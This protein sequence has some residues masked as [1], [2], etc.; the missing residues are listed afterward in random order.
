MLTFCLLS[1]VLI[2]VFS[3]TSVYSTKDNFLIKIV[4]NYVIIINKLIS[5][6]EVNFSCNI[7]FR[8]PNVNRIKFKMFTFWS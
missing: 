8:E 4:K 7:S 5:V 6:G 3:P 1:T 2:S